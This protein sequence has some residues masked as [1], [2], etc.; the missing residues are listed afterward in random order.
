[1][2]TVYPIPIQEYPRSIGNELLFIHYL[3]IRKSKYPR[4]S[5]SDTYATLF[6]LSGLPSILCSSK[7][8]SNCWTFTFFKRINLIVINGQVTIFF[9][10]YHKIC[11]TDDRH[12][13]LNSRCPQNKVVLIDSDEGIFQK[14]LGKQCL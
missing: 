7:I 5:V 14:K 13:T 11:C 9:F 12:G 8:N 4:V 3:W 1:M 2:N 10:T 6:E